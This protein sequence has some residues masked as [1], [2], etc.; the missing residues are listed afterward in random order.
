MPSDLKTWAE[1]KSTRIT[2][3]IRAFKRFEDQKKIARDPEAKKEDDDARSEVA[4]LRPHLDKVIAQ[5][6]HPELLKDKF[7]Q[8]VILGDLEKTLRDLNPQGIETK[9]AVAQMLADIDR[10][11]R[12]LG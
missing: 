4:R 1:N 11:T 5:A 6:K 10:A 9:R 12:R 3:P 2:K 7:E 8:K